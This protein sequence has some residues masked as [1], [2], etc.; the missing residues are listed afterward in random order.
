YSHTQDLWE[1]D[2]S[3]IQSMGIDAIALDM[4]SDDWQPDQVASAYAAASALGTDMKLFI[5]L[6]FSSVS[7]DTTTAI[8]LVSDYLSNSNQFMV[9]NQPMI[10]SYSGECLGGDGWQTIKDST[11]GYIMPFISG[12]EG[13]FDS[14]TALDSWLCWGCAFP[15][16][17]YSANTDSDEYYIEQLGTKYATTV[18]PWMFTHY[19]YKNFYHRGDDFLLNLRWEQLFGMRDNLTFV[20]MLTWND[21]GES[22]Y[23]GP[24]NGNQPTDTTWATDY[25]HTDWADMSKHYITAFKTGTYPSVD[26]DVIYYWARPHSKSA[27]A[28]EDSLPSPTD[29]DWAVDYMWAAIFATADASVTLTIGDSTQTFDNVTAGV[30][31]LRI[32]L[33]TGQISVSMT[34]DGSTIID[35]TDTNFTYTGDTTELYNFNAYV[36]SASSGDSSSNASSSSAVAV[37]ATAVAVSSAA[38]ASSSASVS[39]SIG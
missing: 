9:D 5:S 24:L 37:S 3:S 31:T 17:D 8:S 12:I 35:K 34:R 27:I 36:S 29:G 28:T 11:G 15:Q 20:E 30:N 21:Y 33:A 7:C 13:E 39:I 1:S 19:S 38:A 6:D 16:G 32:P 10:S 18:G 14:W 2:I 4:G 25:S 23:M 22:S 26:T